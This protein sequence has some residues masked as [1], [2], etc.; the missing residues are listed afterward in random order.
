MLADA[1]QAHGPPASSRALLYLKRCS[2]LALLWLAFNGADVRSWIVGA[3]TVL[4]AAWVS[5]KLPPIAQRMPSLGGVLAFAA[6]FLRES[7]RGAWE[8]ALQALQPRLTIAPTV[9]FFSHRLP[10]GGARL[11]FAGAISLLPGTAVI[12][13]DDARIT[14][15]ALNPSP[16]IEWELREL[17]EHVARLFGHPHRDS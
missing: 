13:I 10:P 4:V 8:V 12:A 6:F 11:F 15:H 14:V 9:V 1:Q 3:P 16:R 7:L 5:L 17:E 2:W